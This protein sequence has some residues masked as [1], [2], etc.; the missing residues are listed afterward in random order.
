MNAPRPFRFGVSVFTAKD[1]ADWASKARRAEE[2]GY[3]MLLAPDHLREALAPFPALTAA[4]TATERLRVGTY[5]LNNDFRH[6]AIV[7]REA[8]SLDA[9]SGGRFELGIGAGHMQSEY[10]ETGIRFDPAPVRV[11]R[12]AEAVHIIRALLDGESVTFSG[13][14]YRID[15]HRG[16]PPPAQARLPMLVG[17]NG[18]RVLELAGRFADIVSFTGF[19]PADG[20]RTSKLSHFTNDGLASRIAIVRKAAGVRFAEIEL[21][22][23]V[24]AVVITDDREA[25]AVD[26][27]ARAGVD[28][29]HVLDSPFILAGTPEEIAAQL[30]AQ[31]EAHGVSYISVFEP[32]MEPLAPV[33]ERL[34]GP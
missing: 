22:V 9:V 10:D 20:G 15:G 25:A 26:F 17:G 11:A 3:D 24:Q 4:A 31:R 6:P 30:F 2:L 13:D 5:V 33:I 34:K 21:N 7:A 14:H 29:Q 23:L 8:A 12:L 18:P 1:A 27:A 32:A 16:Y 19:S 28:L